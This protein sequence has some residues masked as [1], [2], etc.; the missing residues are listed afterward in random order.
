MFSLPPTCV[1]PSPARRLVQAGCWLVAVWALWASSAAP[2]S[3]SAARP[4]S[5]V[6]P[7]AAHGT[8]VAPSGHGGPAAAAPQET[9]GT[10]PSEVGADASPRMEIERKV[11]ETWDDGPLEES[12]EMSSFRK[13]LE[14]GRLD[15]R[16]GR[17]AD[18]VARLVALLRSGAPDD[19]KRSAMMELAIAIQDQG[20]LSRA[21][22]TYAQYIQRFPRQPGV[23]EAY[24]RQGLAYRQM[25]ATSIA[26][27]K[28]YA[29][30][31]SALSLRLDQMEYYKRL[32]LQAQV[33][34]A[35]T[36]YLEGRWA[37]A[38]DFLQ[39]LLKSN[40]PQ[41]DVEEVRFKLVRALAAQDKPSEVVGQAQTLI[42]H[43][44][45]S[46]TVPEVRFLL[47]ST[48]KQQGRN[49]EALEQVLQLLESQRSAADRD[50]RA[51]TYWQKR[52]GNE[53]ANQLYREGDYFGTLQIYQRLLTLDETAEWQLPVLYQ[54]GLALER[55]QQPNKAS[56]AYAQ[57]LRREPEIAGS[58]GAS[59][60][61]KTVLEMAR[62][63]QKNLKWVQTA[64]ASAAAIRQVPDPTQPATNHVS[65][66]GNR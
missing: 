35:E 9:E 18:A 25:G 63:R 21:A 7:T 61:L 65:S 62:W 14:D 53:I 34:I 38:V 22:Q 28:F 3:E 32:V 10:P 49:Q 15:R 4:A 27:S 60:S 66:P 54:I 6:L 36:F 16:Q 33:E 64:A 51:W 48:L 50:P 52:A 2:A 12:A 31:T 41:L 13:Q 45:D 39:R 20:E 56:D 17:P 11:R 42:E 5:A 19:L 24:L 30:M 23:I 44:P 58:D 55:L 26:I 8:A 46:G 57:L 1:L 59:P 29:V 40:A 43:H 37:E 47:A